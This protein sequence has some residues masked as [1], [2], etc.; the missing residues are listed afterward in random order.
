MSGDVHPEIRKQSHAAANAEYDLAL[1]WLQSI[2]GKVGR[3]KQMPLSTHGRPLIDY[4]YYG[5][6]TFTTSTLR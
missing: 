3:F 6:I 5:I 2:V 1:D 4:L